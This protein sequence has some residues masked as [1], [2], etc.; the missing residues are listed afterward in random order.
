[1]RHRNQKVVAGCLGG[2]ALSLLLV[3]IVSA[4]FVRHLFQILPAVVALIAV[5]RRPALGSYAAIPIFIFW[6]LIMV[7]IWLYLLGVARIITG[8]FTM[9]EIVLT[10][11]I[12]L[13]SVFGT[14][15]SVCFRPAASFEARTAAFVVFALF[16][17]GTMWVSLLGPFVNR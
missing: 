5:L 15:G 2:L 4:T 17:I 13:L 7:V 8:R 11:L 9:I 12:G 14:I 6:F 16:Q 10:V 1:M 3:G